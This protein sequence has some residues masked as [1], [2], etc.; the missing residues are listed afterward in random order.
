MAKKF[1]FN[2]NTQPTSSTAERMITKAHAKDYG[3]ET[4]SVRTNILFKPSTIEN[5]KKIAV[6]SRTSFNEIVN[7][8]VDDF[9]KQ[10]QEEIELYNQTIGKRGI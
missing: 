7:Q 10:H 5:C 1:D 3:K 8:L 6:I 2:L 9:N 4:K